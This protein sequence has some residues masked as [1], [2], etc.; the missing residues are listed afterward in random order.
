MKKHEQ[1][2]TIEK[3]MEIIKEWFNRPTHTLPA[4]S[5]CNA[6][7]VICKKALENKR[8]GKKIEEKCKNCLHA[9]ETDIAGLLFCQCDGRSKN[10]DMECNIDA[11]ELSDRFL[12]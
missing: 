6:Y 11:F 9:K 8:Y 4:E 3:A 7:E 2:I 12:K 5:V 1:E 10:E